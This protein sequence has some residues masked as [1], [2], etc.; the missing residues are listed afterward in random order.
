MNRINNYTYTF[1]SS[2]L[3][4][5]PTWNPNGTLGSLN[6]SDQFNSANTQNCGYV[7]DDLARISS[8]NCTGS[9]WGQIFTYDQFGNNTKSGSSSWMPGYNTTT[10]QYAGGGATY[11]AN[12]NLTYDTVNHYTWDADAN[13]ATVNGSTNTYD[14]FDKVVETSAGPT[15]FLYLPSGTQPFVTMSNYATFLKVFAPAPGGTMVITPNGKEGVLAYHRHTDWIG[16]SRFATTPAETVYFDGAYAPFGEPYA[17]SGTTDLV[18]GGNAQDASVVE[19]ATA[20]YAYDTLNRKYS[21]AQSRWI[22]PDPASLNAAN[23]LIHRA[24]IDT[25][26]SSTTH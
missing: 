11:D 24:G 6:V 8:V 16:S 12:G 25:P 9:G 7:Y 22:S 21:A 19:G 10:N 17:L 2:S 3:I 20:G 1:G 26:T 5:V 14:A 15:Q 13:I 23:Q 4:G 18:F